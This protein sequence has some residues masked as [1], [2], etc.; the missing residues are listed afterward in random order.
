MENQRQ[1][2]R[3][4]PNI[5]RRKATG[6]TVGPHGFHIQRNG[7]SDEESSK[8]D[9]EPRDNRVMMVT[10]VSNPQ[11]IASSSPTRNVRFPDD[12]IEESSSSSDEDSP[13]RPNL[14]NVTQQ[15]KPTAIKKAS[16]QDDRPTPMKM[17]DSENKLV[18]SG[19]TGEKRPESKSTT[20]EAPIHSAP[21]AATN[22]PP[23]GASSPDS[24]PVSGAFQ[25]SPL[26]TSSMKGNWEEHPSTK[27]GAILK[28]VRPL[29]DE[30][31]VKRSFLWN[32]N[33]DFAEKM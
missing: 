12:P 20:P 33:S 11:S 1:R 27:T 24:P 6:D 15:P 3:Q 30:K 16:R 9:D 22:R 19:H 23:S 14:Q 26:R 25:H 5:A 31:K 29:D 10:S 8:S 21:G 4:S 2:Q 18:L 28:K 32:S 17:D 13:P 7:S